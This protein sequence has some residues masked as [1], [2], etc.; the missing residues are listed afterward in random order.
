MEQ[1]RIDKSTKSSVVLVINKQGQVSG[2]ATTIPDANKLAKA[3][4]TPPR[5]GCGPGCGPA[6]CG[7]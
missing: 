6:G 2:T 4:I 3:V 1:L 5:G 7:K